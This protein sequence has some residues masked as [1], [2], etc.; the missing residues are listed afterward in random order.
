MTIASALSNSVYYYDFGSTDYDDTVF[1]GLYSALVNQQNGM[2]S[3]SNQFL[4]T[5]ID[6]YQN[7]RYD[8]A[9]K[10]FEASIAIAP[11]SSYNTDTTKYLSQTYLKLEEPDKAFATYKSAIERNPQ[12]DDLRTSLAQLY[13]AEEEYE[14]AAVQYK[15][16]VQINPSS[17]NRYSYGESLLKVENYTEAEYQFREVRRLEPE[18]YAGDYGLRENVRS[19]RSV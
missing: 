19:V 18:S 11:N 10:A 3:L 6:H 7:E 5:G 2:E 12:D 13:Y 9:A 14:D 1:N 16:A 8:E 15:A 4:Q 17:T